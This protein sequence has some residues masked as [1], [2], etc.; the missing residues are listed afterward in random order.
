MLRLAL[1]P[2][3]PRQGQLAM[4]NTGILMVSNDSGICLQNFASQLFIRFG[5]EF[6]ILVMKNQIVLDERDSEPS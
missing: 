1:F 4:P 5:W 2:M 3:V 6:A